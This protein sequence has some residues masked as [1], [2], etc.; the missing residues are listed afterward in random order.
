MAD[1]D[2]LLADFA[3][4]SAELE[5]LVAPL[6]PDGWRLPTPAP[7]WTI[8]HQIGHLAWTDDVAVLSATDPAG[9]AAMLTAVGPRAATFVDEAPRRRRP[10]RPPRCWNAGAR[11]AP[12]W[13]RRC[14]RCRRARRCRGSARP[15]GRVR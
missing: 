5:R 7:G 8:A 14:A 4:E 1:L 15:C 3:A 10:P 13:S 11:A 12:R 2:A 9:F 6:G